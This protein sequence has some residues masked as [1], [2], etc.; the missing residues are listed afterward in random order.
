M[1][2]RRVDS[3]NGHFRVHH[4]DGRIS[5]SRGGPGHVMRGAYGAGPGNSG[6][7]LRPLDSGRSRPRAQRVAGTPS[8]SVSA[9]DGDDIEI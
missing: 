5:E 9:S 3:L 7:A 1:T 2:R 4:R 6:L 8:Q